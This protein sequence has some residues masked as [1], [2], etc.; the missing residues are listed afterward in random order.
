[1]AQ[2][3]LQADRTLGT[4]D[5]DARVTSFLR[6]VYSWMC[7][8]LGVTAFVAY[9]VAQSPAVLSAIAANR[10]IYW[11]L[12]LAQLG[13]VFW[14]SARVHKM[15][16]GTASLLFLLYSGLTGL[17]FSFILLAFT[18]QSI[19]TTF[20]TCATMFGALALYGTTTSRSLAGWG[21]FLFMGLVGVVIASIVGMFWHS[22][23][24]QF[25]ISVIGVI[26]FTGLTAYDAQ[27]LRV[28]AT[29]MPSGQTGSYAIVGALTLYLDFINLFLMLLRFTGSR[30]N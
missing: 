23:G 11:V 14:L 20:L 28:M 25:V 27:R 4:T 16:P 18:G 24:L 1:M 30:R 12:L 2:Y 10:G 5:V 7:A 3:D 19:A 17:T 26:V 29:A 15:A 6:S 9:A 13:L 8:G 21:Q 22:D